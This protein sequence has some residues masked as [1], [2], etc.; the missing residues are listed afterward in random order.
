MFAIRSGWL[1][2]AEF[3]W[4]AEAL[5]KSEVAK[6][7]RVQ[8]MRHAKAAIQREIPVAIAALNV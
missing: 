5:I 4:I 6:L 3:L 7:G 1:C 2:S 8:P